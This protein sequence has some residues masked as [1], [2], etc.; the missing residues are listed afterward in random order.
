MLELDEEFLLGEV[1]AEPIAECGKHDVPDACAK[2][3]EQGK[4]AEIH[5]RQSGGNGDELPDCRNE[6]AQEGGDGAVAVK[7]G[8]GFLHLLGIDEAHVPHPAV[9]KGIDDRAANEQRQ[10]VVDDGSDECAKGGNE[11]NHHHVHVAVACREIGSR[12]D[13][14]LAGEWDEG[15]LDGHEQQDGAVG[16]VLFIPVV[17]GEDVV[18]HINHDGYRCSEQQHENDD[19]L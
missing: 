4:G 6:A 13:D 7:I 10:D 17:N 19:E 15:A 12:R 1:L 5:A 16:E 3:S 9:G 2:G 11:D 18:R 8:F 14:D